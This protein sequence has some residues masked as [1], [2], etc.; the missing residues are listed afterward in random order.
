MRLLRQHTETEVGL[1]IGVSQPSVSAW[2]SGQARPTSI[3][4]D[5]LE[6][7]YGIPRSAWL[8]SAERERMAGLSTSRCS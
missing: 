5:L 8:T 6:S 2:K 3:R 4:Q 1:N 7:V